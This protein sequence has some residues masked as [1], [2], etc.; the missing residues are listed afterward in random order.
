MSKEKEFAKNTV[1]LL[2]GK[3]MTQLLTFLLL[4]LYTYKL[5]TDDYGYIDLLQTY[6]SLLVP[7]VLL[8]LDS[9]V[10]RFL[11]EYR[12]DSIK[13]KEIITNSVIFIFFIAIVLILTSF[14]LS[15]IFVINYFYLIVL[16][17]LAL[18]INFY[19]LSISRGFSDSVTYS[20]S[21]II[22]CVITFIVNLVLILLC[23]FDGKSILIASIIANLCA[24]IYICIKKKV[25]EY[26]CLRYLS[27]EMLKELLKYS[28]PMIP[29]VISWWIVGLSDRT[30][31]TYFIST[32]A[33][34]IYSVACKF[35][36]LINSIFAIF[37]ISWQET[38]S[39][40]INDEDANEFFSKMIL[41]IYKIFVMLSCGIIGF[42]P[43]VFNIVIGNEY[44]DAYNYIPI[45][46]LANICYVMDGLLGGIY[47]AKKM[48]KKVAITTTVSAIINIAINFILIKKIALFAASISTLIAYLSITI[49][50]YWDIK[51]FINIKLNINSILIYIFYYFVLMIL[52]YL[53]LKIISI[54]VLCIIVSLYVIENRDIILKVINK[55][56][57]R[58]NFKKS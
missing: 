51:K 58:L 28:I 54:I 39:I 11:I 17:I 6:I 14:I 40:H 10:F 48:I 3:F 44:I 52:Y 55:V 41:S 1:V 27:K 16:N 15:K 37:N 56:I 36:N 45:L 32:T 23:G 33:N 8:Q 5:A 46:I 4:P 19:F 18:M 57:N 21:S 34:A 30:M 7:I 53:Q 49:Y 31:I 22:T 25:Y 38:A 50:R 2:I 24:S 13:Q 26:I 20:I 29:N 47:V 35:S 42:L 43:L 12:K 9:A